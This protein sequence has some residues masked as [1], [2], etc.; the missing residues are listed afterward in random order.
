M[1][2]DPIDT[3]AAV[4]RWNPEISPW[5]AAADEGRLLIKRCEACG[6]AHYYPRSLCPFCFSD[7]TVWVESAGAGVVYSF[8]VEQR[9][10]APFIIAYVTLDEG[11]TVMTNIVAAPAADA[12]RI[13]V[14]V[15]LD[16]EESRGRRAP[17]FR[18]SPL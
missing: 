10:S 9:G 5:R 11:P 12:L 15:E 3:P 7:R 4:A 14:R 16:P 8:A 13:G 2:L 6:V 1:S 17:M 18:L